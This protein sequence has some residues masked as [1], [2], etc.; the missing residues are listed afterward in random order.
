MV[1]LADQVPSTTASSVSRYATGAE[2]ARIPPSA[3]GPAV[4]ARSSAAYGQARSLV[5]P[6]RMT[7]AVQMDAIGPTL[8]SLPK[9]GQAQSERSSLG[10]T[11]PRP[12]GDGE[13]R[14]L[15]EAVVP[16]AV[17]RVSDQGMRR[18]GSGSQLVPGQTMTSVPRANTFGPAGAAAKSGVPG[19]PAP[20]QAPTPGVPNAAVSAGS[21][22][23]VHGSLPGSGTGAPRSI[24]FSAYAN[25]KP[26][27]AGVASGGGPGV[28]YNAAKAQPGPAPGS[29]QH[30][31]PQALQPQASPAVST[32]G[33]HAQSRRSHSPTRQYSCA[34]VL[35]HA[36][37]Q[38]VGPLSPFPSAQ[39]AQPP[40]QMAPVD[41]SQRLN[42]ANELQ[43][44]L[45]G[46]PATGTPN[47]GGPGVLSHPRTPARSPGPPAA[48]R[49]PLPGMHAPS[50]LD[51]ARDHAGSF[52][53]EEESLPDPLGLNNLPPPPRSA[54]AA[55]SMMSGGAMP[56]RGG[57]GGL[58]GGPAQF[59]LKVLSSDSRWETLSFAPAD[60][61]ETVAGDFLRRAGL[62]G[63]F[64]AGLTAKMRSMLSSGQ[65]TASVDIVDLI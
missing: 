62:K 46:V 48:V 10:G 7:S 41:V 34:A 20:Q 14:H 36:R 53:E 43:Q 11:Y 49:R 27:P 55:E 64:Q 59:M 16:K 26:P 54:P 29:L 18:Q 9:R 37:A 19:Y 65:T 44:R 3:L 33:S 56:R 23:P 28:T 31:G 51:W 6:S 22:G 40:A 32:P 30:S 52:R 24:S 58:P 2:S 12:V 63:A 17:A 42:R 35:Q 4:S 21:G 1:D 8:T 47:G 25:V 5:V 60:R 45:L 39:S 61:L 50:L 38:H 15:S 13:T 57:C